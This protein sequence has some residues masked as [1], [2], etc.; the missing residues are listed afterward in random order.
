MRGWVPPDDRLWLHPSE[1]ASAGLRPQTVGTPGRA[2]TGR[3]VI[4]G[5]A[6]CVAVTM[7]VAIVVLTADATREVSSPTTTWVTGV[8]TTEANLQ[9]LS[10]VKRMTTVATSA[11][12]STVALLVGRA[13]GTSTATGV[14][15]EAGGIVVALRSVVAGARSITVV[16]PGGERESAMYLGTDT[17]TGI[18]VLH[19][20]D[21]L[22]PA[23]MTDGDPATG[24]VVVAMAMESRVRPTRRRPPASTPAPSCSPGWAAEPRRRGFC[25]TGVA[26]PLT[27]GDLGSPLVDSSGS[28]VG[29]LEAVTGTGSQRTS[30]FLP[31]D[32]VRDVAAQIVSH[33]WVNHGD[34]GLGDTNAPTVDGVGSGALVESV[35]TGGAAAQAG[36]RV[37]DVIVGVDGNDVRSVAE[38]NTRLYAD[39]PGS[40][41]R[42]T[43]VR[44]GVTFHTIV[45]LTELIFR[46]LTATAP[47]AAEPTP[48]WRRSMGA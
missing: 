10:D 24:S 30:V 44:D 35:T 3:W 14:V 23:D 9:Q 20:D 4:G 45:V 26:A 31:A 12:D 17:G 6:A 29:I 16:E 18:T 21:D 46:R 32:L 25:T 41:L 34:V 1:R 39:P 27:S 22:P 33:G 8:P 5:M 48:G 37:G 2:S 38:L 42:F 19:I 13:S 11:H 47:G 15:V 40:A 28:V 43:V 7:V 36:L